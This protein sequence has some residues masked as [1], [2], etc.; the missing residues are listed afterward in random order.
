[1]QPKI[2]LLSTVAAFAYRVPV[3]LRATPYES[4]RAGDSA[5][6]RA[7]DARDLGQANVS[8]LGAVLSAQASSPWFWEAGAG[9]NLHFTC[10]N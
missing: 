3:S 6:P 7:E 9:S 4:A 5:T 1:M 8:H 10:R 2:S